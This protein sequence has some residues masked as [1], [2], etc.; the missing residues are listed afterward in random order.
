MTK[1]KRLRRPSGTSAFV[2]TDDAKCNKTYT[3]LQKY[4]AYA[5][6]T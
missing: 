1:D 5:A 6:P 2:K 4:M 3:Y